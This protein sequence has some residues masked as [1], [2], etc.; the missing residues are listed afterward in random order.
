MYLRAR[1]IP[2]NPATPQQE[3]I[4]QAAS[5][6]VIRWSDDLTP[7]QRSAWNTYAANVTL[8]GRQGDAIN[9]SGQSMYIR[10]N[11]SLVQ[12][13][14]IIV[15]TAPILFNLGSF[16][17]PSFAP[18]AATDVVDVSFDDTDNWAN[19]DDA[20]LL[21][22]LSRP[23]GPSIT[24]FKGPYRF[25]GLIA[26]DAITPPTSPASIPAPF[27]FEV[28]HRVFA[29]IRATQGDGRLSDTFRGFGTAT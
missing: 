13:G 26:G 27:V 23:Q 4:R 11:V 12:A 9:V 29:S 28:G 15:D 2:V 8:T 16:T 10:S 21:V 19:T 14:L 18:V 20:A 24:F 25:A 6:L 22:Y 3:T 5:F 7:A 1:T 17:E